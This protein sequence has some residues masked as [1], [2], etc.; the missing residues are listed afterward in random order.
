MSASRMQGVALYKRSR[1]R[2]ELDDNKADMGLMP[3]YAQEI[4]DY[5]LHTAAIENNYKAIR[6][7][8]KMGANPD[9]WIDAHGGEPAGSLLH[10]AVR[11]CSL[12]TVIAL[13]QLGADPFGRDALNATP[14]DVAQTKLS[15]SRM[16]TVLKLWEQ[17]KVQ[18][19]I[20]EEKVIDFERLLRGKAS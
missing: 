10:F 17:R 1:W 8:V 9:M 2:K 15:G 7:M 19:A 11:R 3:P 4:L 18:P 12:K 5:S 14:R 16:K 6:E 20:D 13:L